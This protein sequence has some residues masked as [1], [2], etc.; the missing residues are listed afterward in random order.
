MQLADSA[1]DA[2]RRASR[3]V[4]HAQLDPDEWRQTERQIFG[5]I[6]QARSACSGGETEMERYAIREVQGVLASMQSMAEVLSRVARSEESIA[7][8]TG[9]FDGLDDR[10]DHARAMVR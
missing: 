9:A 3:S 10:L 2:L 4:R 5:V 1:S 8:S 7:E 6:T